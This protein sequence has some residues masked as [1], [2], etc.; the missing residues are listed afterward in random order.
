MRRKGENMTSEKRLELAKKALISYMRDASFYH[1]QI[2][3]LIAVYKQI[4]HNA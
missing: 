4:K 2:V 3:R 1:E